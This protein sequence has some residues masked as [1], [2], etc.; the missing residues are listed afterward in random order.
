MNGNIS[1]LSDHLIGRLLLRQMWQIHDA[2]GVSLGRSARSL[3]LEA[4]LD[5]YP[6][7]N[8]HEE[9]TQDM[10]ICEAKKRE[11]RKIFKPPQLL[12]FNDLKMLDTYSLMYLILLE[13]YEWYKKDAEENDWPLVEEISIIEAVM[14]MFYPEEDVSSFL[15]ISQDQLLLESK[16]RY[17]ER[18]KKHFSYE[19]S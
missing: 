1:C 3:L 16:D 8:C 7:D 4:V 17:Y 2:S 19:R 9:F 5:I 14:P 13:L 10:L 11:A 6:I 15:S 12:F 18:M